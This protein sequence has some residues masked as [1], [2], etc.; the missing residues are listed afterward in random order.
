MY[1]KILVEPGIT[2]EKKFSTIKIMFIINTWLV[3]IHMI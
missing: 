2:C 3:P 1:I